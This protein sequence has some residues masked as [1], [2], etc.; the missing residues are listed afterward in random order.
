MLHSQVV[1]S[2]VYLLAPSLPQRKAFHS[3]KSPTKD[4]NRS[5]KTDQQNQPKEQTNPKRLKTP[6]LSL[7]YKQPK[8]TPSKRPTKPHHT[9]RTPL[10]LLFHQR[11]SS[12]KPTIIPTSYHQP[13]SLRL[14]F[15]A[16]L[17]LLGLPFAPPCC[18]R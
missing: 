6:L 11:F 1:T 14:L 16:T 9:T 17:P 4:P 8:E 18:A 10:R 15:L 3:H 13:S 12:P 7:L 2:P 5:V